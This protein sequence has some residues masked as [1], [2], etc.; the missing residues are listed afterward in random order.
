M[1]VQVDELLNEIDDVQQKGV[2]IK[3]TMSHRV[4]LG[5]R[6]CHAHSISS[7]RAYDSHTY[8]TYL[9]RIRY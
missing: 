4:L 8:R 2:F 1:N 6:Q 3:L 5:Q 9:E 7:F